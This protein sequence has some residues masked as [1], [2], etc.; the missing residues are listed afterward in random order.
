MSESVLYSESDGLAVI[1]INRPEK[2]NSLTREVI[3]GIANGVDLATASGEVS[4]LVLRGQGGTL[5]SGYDLI[6]Y[7]RKSQEPGYQT[8][9][10]ETRE[11]AWDPVKDYEWM[12]S[13]VRKFM[14]IWECPKPVLAEISGWAIGGATDLILCADLLYMASDSHI[15]YAPSRIFGTPTTMMWIYRLGLEHAKQFLLTGRA[16][17]AQ[18]AFRIGLVSEVCPPSELSQI[19]EREARRLSEIPSNQMALNKMLINQAYENMGLR[20][21]QM[22]GTFF[23]GMARHTEEAYR[24]M[25]SFE[26]KGFRE[27]IRERDRPWG[28]Y[29]EKSTNSP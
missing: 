29:G 2:K 4:A 27:A 1:A 16:I 17:D 25:E 10:P 5:T 19:V 6:E 21:S 18:T 20:T 28:D 9:G 26:T 24:W 22:L 13:N 7:S 14:K 11:G 8:Y 3:E 23:D 15:G 12:R